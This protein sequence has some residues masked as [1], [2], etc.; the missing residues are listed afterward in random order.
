MLDARAGPAG[1]FAPTEDARALG[2]AVITLMVNE[3]VA[4][5]IR[6]SATQRSSQWHSEQFG[7]RLREIYR[8]VAGDQ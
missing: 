8:Q 6:Q 3:E 5:A 7:Q 2:A 4:E 1:Y